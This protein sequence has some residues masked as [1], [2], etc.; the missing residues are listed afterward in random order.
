MSHSTTLIGTVSQRA[1]AK[2]GH[3]N[4]HTKAKE[5]W[6]T[7]ARQWRDELQAEGL[8]KTVEQLNKAIAFFEKG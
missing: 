3:V 2:H 5:L 4:D 6:L 1:I 7:E 8:T